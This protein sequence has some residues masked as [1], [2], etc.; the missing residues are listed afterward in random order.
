M[1]YRRFRNKSSYWIWLRL[2]GSTLCN[3]ATPL[4]ASLA[5]KKAEAVASA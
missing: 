3:D 4:Q 5:R 1:R 2:A